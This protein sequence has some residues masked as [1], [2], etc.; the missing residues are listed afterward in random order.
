VK[1][2]NGHIHLAKRFE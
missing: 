1:R 2:V